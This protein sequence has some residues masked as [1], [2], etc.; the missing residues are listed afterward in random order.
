MLNMIVI[1]FFFLKGEEIFLV[2]GNVYL[3]PFFYLWRN[4][5]K[6]IGE[7]FCDIFH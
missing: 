5:H 3:Y 1:V 4:M 2:E 6:N 7:N